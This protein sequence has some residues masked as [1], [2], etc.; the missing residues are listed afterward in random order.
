[1]TCFDWMHCLHGQTE[2][3]CNKVFNIEKKIKAY[4]Q[5]IFFVDSTVSLYYNYV[6][7][8]LQYGFIYANIAA[9]NAWMACRYNRN[10]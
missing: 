7:F 5:Q 4:T 1:M 9:I 6:V 10:V 2:L 8:V 3:H